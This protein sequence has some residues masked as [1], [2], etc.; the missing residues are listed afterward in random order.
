MAFTP[1]VIT[2]RFIRMQPIRKVSPCKSW[3][4]E[5]CILE[6]YI[7]QRSDIPT[8]KVFAHTAL[9][10]SHECMCILMQK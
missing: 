8:V 2:F 4:W 5:T 6:P 3:T 9:Y 7:Y 10:D 1:I